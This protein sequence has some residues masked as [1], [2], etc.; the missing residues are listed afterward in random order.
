MTGA[1]NVGS[2]LGF[3]GASGLNLDLLA[4]GEL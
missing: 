2:R 4:A 1:V 3:R